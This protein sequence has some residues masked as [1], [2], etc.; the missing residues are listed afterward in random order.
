M[1][2]FL[3]PDNRVCAGLDLRSV[4]ACVSEPVP[5][6]LLAGSPAI[7]SAVDSIRCHCQNLNEPGCHAALMEHRQAEEK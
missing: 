1:E 4:R 7:L 5:A 3:S 2:I 6:Q